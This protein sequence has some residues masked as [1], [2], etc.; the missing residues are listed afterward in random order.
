M[1]LDIALK[2]W[3]AVCHAIHTG[4]Q[5][6]LLRKGGIHET[7]GRFEIQNRDFLL[8]PTYLHQKID[9]VKPNDRQHVQHRDDEPDRVEIN[10]RVC[11]TDIVRVRSR[12]QMDAIDYAHLYLPPMIDMRFNYK[13][14]NP[15]YLLIIRAY[16]LDVVNIASVPLYAG[17]KS[18]VPLESPIDISQARA[19]LSVADF[20]R[21]RR[22]LLSTLESIS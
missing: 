21:Q 11:V 19:V 13:P 5:I 22:K 12:Q 8:F 16:R 10:T 14:Q 20:E 15:L 17:C 18:W 9:W 3:Q 6:I 7:E 4:R 1:T 2:E